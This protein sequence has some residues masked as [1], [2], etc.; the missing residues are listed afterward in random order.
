MCLRGRIPPG[1][2]EYVDQHAIRKRIPIQAKDQ[3]SG[4]TGVAVQVPGA[5]N[6]PAI[7]GDIAGGGEYANGGTVVLEIK[8]QGGD[9]ATGGTERER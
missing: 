8:L 6:L 2:H 5:E 1:I 7:P 4:L 9:G 3:K